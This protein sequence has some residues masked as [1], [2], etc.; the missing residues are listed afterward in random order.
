M[1]TELAIHTE[2]KAKIYVPVP[3][4]SKIPS[5]DSNTAPKNVFLNPIQEFNRDLSI[6]AIRTWSQVFAKEK[7][8]AWD[9]RQ[10]NR[11]NKAAKRS[12][13]GQDEGPTGKRRKGE[14]G[15]PVQVGDV[16]DSVLDQVSPFIPR[17]LSHWVLNLVL[18][19]AKG[20]H[21]ATSTGPL[22]IYRL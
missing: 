11:K 10:A 21:R 5:T 22:Q 4:G 3:S 9:R 16:V 19:I 17:H 2:G 14:D 18:Y 1:S 13:S 7:L 8:D 20:I 12:A 15:L 6:V